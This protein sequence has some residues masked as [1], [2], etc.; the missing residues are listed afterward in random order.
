MC[1]YTCNGLEGNR[2]DPNVLNFSAVI[3][4]C[5]SIEL[6]THS[7]EGVTGLGYVTKGGEG[8]FIC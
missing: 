1:V 4:L 6:L 7:G 5:V 2:N 3:C 8:L